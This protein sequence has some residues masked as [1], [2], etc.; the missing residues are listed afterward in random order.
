MRY[1]LI[2]NNRITGKNYER[3]F[4]VIRKQVPDNFSFEEI[5]DKIES[6]HKKRV[7]IP[8]LVNS[9]LF[10]ESLLQGDTERVVPRLKEKLKA[11]N[12]IPYNKKQ[13]AEIL[14][15]INGQKKERLR[16]G[17]S[18][19]IEVQ[20]DRLFWDRKYISQHQN[21]S[22]TIKSLLMTGL[23][24]MQLTNYVD[25]KILNSLDFSSL[26][27][28]SMTKGGE[29]ID[30][31]T[32]SEVELILAST[33]F[34]YLKQFEGLSNESAAKKVE[35]D[36]QMELDW[37]TLREYYNSLALL[38]SK[39]LHVDSTPILKVLEK[40]THLIQDLQT[41]LGEAVLNIDTSEG[42]LKT[43]KDINK[44]FLTLS[45]GLSGL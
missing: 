23:L 6:L 1:D 29:T 3:L 5:N 24:N 11:L 26:V 34:F 38:Y 14:L 33:Y 10:W 18:E 8:N 12:N 45:R 44:A 35:K 4:K 15:K 41:R 19:N 25:D 21:I 27:R 28:L 2:K 13:I 30:V 20:L 32:Y 42:F 9:K 22:E 39:E 16:I 17:K 31:P 40:V 7:K 43:Y 37:A 36:L